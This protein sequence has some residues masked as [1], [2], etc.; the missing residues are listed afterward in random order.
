[1]TV[2]IIRPLLPLPFSQILQL[3]RQRYLEEG[4]KGHVW[5]LN[6]L[7]GEYL[8]SGESGWTLRVP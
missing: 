8:A 6:V 5:T 2:S 3:A 4:S 7:S 1:M